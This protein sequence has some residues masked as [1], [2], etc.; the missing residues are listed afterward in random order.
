MKR[1]A[2]PPPSAI[3]VIVTVA[4][5]NR[6]LT[7]RRKSRRYGLWVNTD[8]VV[9]DSAPTFYAVATTA[10]WEDVITDTEDLRY[11][12]SIPRAIRSVGNLVSDSPAFTEALIRI[13]QG[14]GQYLSLPR[15]V[16][17]TEATLFSVRVALPANLT[18]GEY[19][20]RIF[21]TRDGRVID[22]YVTEIGVEK[23]GLERAI[24]QMARRWPLSYGL[25]CLVIATVAGWG[26]SELFR[27]IRS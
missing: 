16:T 8:A 10:P 13:R 27:Y 20:T 22:E 19:R 1:E 23:T 9:V 18:E 2:Q 24:F 14:N 7:V 6:E 17:L 15:T 4:G 21:L 26:A 5:P 11:K 12:I 25:L 3:G